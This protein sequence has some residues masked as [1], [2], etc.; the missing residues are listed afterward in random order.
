MINYILNLLTLATIY[1]IAAASL[2][3]LVG[4]A[5]IFSIAHAIF[6]GLGAYA[7]AQFAL[8]IVPDVLLASLIGAVVSGAFS[9][10]LA[11]PALRVRGEYFV[12]AGL[13]L[14]MVGITI[15]S[16]AHSLTGGHGGLVGIP[17]ATLFGFDVSSPGAFLA[18]C[19]VALLLSLAVIQVLMRSSFGRALMSIRDNESAAESFGKNVPLL[20]TLAMVVGCAIVGVAGTLFAFNLAFINVESFTLEQSILMLAMVVIG[21]VGTLSGPLIGAVFLLILPAILT[22]IP[23]IP[24][25]EIGTVQQF[26]YGSL[27]AVLMIFKPSG[28]AG[29]T[30]GK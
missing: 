3:V 14:Q 29:K 15:F 5:G 2:N 1:S 9:L 13:G 12:A 26:I 4:Y 18:V 25:T 30:G 19:L 7:G 16:E 6:F 23:F 22:F 27:M 28:I 24:P 10:L 17:P 20:K 21:G 11:L 8:L